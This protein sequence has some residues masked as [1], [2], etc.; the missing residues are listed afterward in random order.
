MFLDDKIQKLM[1]ADSANTNS[2]NGNND[3]NK[4]INSDTNT[5]PN[6]STEVV[7]E[8]INASNNKY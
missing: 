5:A 7:A 2:N 3:Q 1:N 8:N 6:H 4:S